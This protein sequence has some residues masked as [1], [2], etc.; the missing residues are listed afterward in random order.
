MID[1]PDPS[2]PKKQKNPMDIIISG[3][4]ENSLTKIQQ[5][6]DIF[7]TSPKRGLGSGILDRVLKL[8]VTQAKP[9][10]VRYLLDETRYKFGEEELG[11][12]L[13]DVIAVLDILVERGWDINRGPRRSSPDPSNPDYLIYKVCG[14]EKLIRW[15]LDNGAHVA[16]PDVEWL[17]PLL[18]A[19]AMFGNISSVELL[20][21]RGAKFGRRTL[22]MA[23]L[24]A[25]SRSPE[26]FGQ[27]ME[28]VRYLVEEKGCDVNGMDM[29]EGERYGNHYGTPLNYLA[30][31]TVPGDRGV[32][33]I[34]RYLLEKGADP[35]IK[36]GY[37]II[38]AFGYAK[39]NKNIL[40][41]LNN[42]KERKE[43]E[44]M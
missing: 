44:N 40:D 26:R 12:R 9:D 6:L 27:R 38:D 30:H 22:H 8:A 42:W 21:S 16:Y 25:A 13:Q 14:S 43:N 24:S 10:I 5:G 4:A 11:Y 34:A 15:C 3:L 31:R 29:P 18:V 32:E 1:Q 2:T 36:D 37:G 35:E 33:E 7:S 41:I 28:M 17:T 19:V 23:C 39:R 20:L